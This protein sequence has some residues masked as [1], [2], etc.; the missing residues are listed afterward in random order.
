MS[1]SDNQPDR[2][3]AAAQWINEAHDEL[4]AARHE[5][6]LELRKRRERGGRQPG[7]HGTPAGYRQHQRLQQP[8]CSACM[9]AWAWEWRRVNHGDERA[10]G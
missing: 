5:L 8:A 3:E 4:R 6:F 7:K 10:A 9:E 1:L 2:L